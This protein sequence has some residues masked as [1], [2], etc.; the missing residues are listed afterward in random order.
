MA[1]KSVKSFKIDIVDNTA[2]VEIH[3]ENNKPYKYQIFPDDVQGDIIGI[4]EHLKAGL[5]EAMNTFQKIEVSEFFERSYVTIV[6]PIERVA[7]RYTA[8]KL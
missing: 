1:R 2:I 5:S 6:T 8:N 4:A 3:T 7:N